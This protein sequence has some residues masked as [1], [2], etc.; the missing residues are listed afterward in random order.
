MQF[1]YVLPV[2]IL[3]NVFIS[4]MLKE[5]C[6]FIS[7]RAFRFPELGKNWVLRQILEG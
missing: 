6:E 3:T 4:G 7:W 1:Y 5:T 2:E